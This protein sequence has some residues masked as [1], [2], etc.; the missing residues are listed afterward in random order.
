MSGDSLVTGRGRFAVRRMGESEEPPVICLH[1][2]PDDASTF[3]G[4]ASALAQAGHS[5]VSP[6]L[7][8]YAPSPLEGPL[9]IEALVDDLLAITDAL[10]PDRPVLF[11]GHDYGAQIG[12]AALAREPGRFAA[13]VTLAGAHPAAIG[14]NMKRLP[15]QWW[16]SRYIVFFQMGGFADKRVALRN[17]AYVETLWRRWSPGFHP[18]AGHLDRVKATLAKSMPAPVA[19]YRE[20]GFEIGKDPIATPT[21]FVCGDQDGCLLPALSDGQDALF[22][23]G[24]QRQ[25]W[26]DVGHFPHLEQLARTADAVLAWFSTHDP[27]P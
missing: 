16:M 9:T 1:G 11:V 8:G 14:K 24:Y 27:R 20:G 5:V 2:F 3:D 6:Y 15:R 26:N 10:S 12:Y 13:A 23:G 19:M 7:R 22:T 17:F 4:L 25:V 18:P 21:L